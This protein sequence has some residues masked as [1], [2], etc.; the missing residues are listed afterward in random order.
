MSANVQGAHAVDQKQRKR[1]VI[2]GCDVCQYSMQRPGGPPTEPLQLMHS[3]ITPERP[4]SAMR[5]DV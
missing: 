4:F 1:R 5:H 2:E 3:S